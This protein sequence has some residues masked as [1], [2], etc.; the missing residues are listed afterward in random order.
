MS[1]S[2]SAIPE[3]RRF[4][5][6]DF[7]GEFDRTLAPPDLEEQVRSLVLVDELGTIRARYEDDT[8][9]WISMAPQRAPGG[10][11]L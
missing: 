3:R 10:D 5:L 2:S 1:G 11:A 9:I 4:D 6:P 7:Y 8:L